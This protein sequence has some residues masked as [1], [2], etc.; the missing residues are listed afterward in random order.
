MGT[1]A[2]TE[3]KIRSVLPANYRWLEN[4]CAIIGGAEF[5]GGTMWFPDTPPDPAKDR[6]PDPRCR[7]VVDA[8]SNCPA[9]GQ[10]WISDFRLIEGF[11]EW[12]HACNS[13]FTDAAKRLVRPG[14]V[15]VSHHLPRAACRRNTPGTR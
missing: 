8:S 5:F 2:A 13:G 10:T 1:A 7:G 11:R 3:F 4:E 14:T 15:V 12:V 6:C 9:C